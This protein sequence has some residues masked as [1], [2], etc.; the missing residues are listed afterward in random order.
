MA[1]LKSGKTPEEFLRDAAEAVVENSARRLEHEV[2]EAMAQVR[3][4]ALALAELPKSSNDLLAAA[5]LAVSADFDVGDNANWDARFVSVSIGREGVSLRDENYGG[6]RRI[7]Q[8]KYR[9]LLF[10]LP[11][12]P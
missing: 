12:K 3:Q 10:V 1:D 8:G 6:A 7:P 4:A 5:T 9:A 11:L 2:A